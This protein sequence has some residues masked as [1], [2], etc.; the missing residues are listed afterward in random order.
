[1]SDNLG[2][3]LQLGERWHKWQLALPQ[4][5]S[6]SIE[7]IFTLLVKEILGFELHTF[8]DASI[9]GYGVCDNTFKC[10]FVLGKLRVTPSKLES[11]SRPKLIT[12]VF[13]KK[14]TNFVVN[15]FEMKFS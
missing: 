8:S 4:L 12:P 9:S 15:K 10:C 5:E 11:V 1:M 13:A 2:D 6:A 7:R 3:Y 14:T